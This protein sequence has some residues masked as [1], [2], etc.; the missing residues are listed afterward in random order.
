MRYWAVVLSVVLLAGCST[1]AA[2]ST[3]TETPTVVEREVTT[4]TVSLAGLPVSAEFTIESPDPSFE[5]PVTVKFKRPKMGNYTPV[6]VFRVPEGEP[7][8][9]KLLPD[10]AYLIEVEDAEGDPC[11][12]GF[13]RYDEEGP[14]PTIII[15]GGDVTSC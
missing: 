13:Y 2:P 14:N 6:Q 3:P 5:F 7:F 10:E 1:T 8:S 9:V 4:G 15:N 11:T 12:L